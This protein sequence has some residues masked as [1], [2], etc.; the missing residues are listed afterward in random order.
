MTVSMCLTISCC[1]CGSLTWL[2]YCYTAWLESISLSLSIAIWKADCQF[3]VFKLF[4]YGAAPN[5]YDTVVCMLDVTSLYNAAS[6]V[7][8]WVVV[9]CYDTQLM[10][11]TL[12]LVNWQSLSTTA[13][14]RLQHAW[15]LRTPMLCHSCQLSL[16]STPLNCSSTASLWK[17][18]YSHHIELL[19]SVYVIHNIF[20]A[21]AI[22]SRWFCPVWSSLNNR[23]TTVSLYFFSFWSHSVN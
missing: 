19:I 17:V 15:L 2:Y 22:M 18:R 12:V 5:S 3:I 21:T 14:F 1:W 6:S 11:T 13:M 8:G 20:C 9:P 23:D 7:N 16:E 10:Q 4:A